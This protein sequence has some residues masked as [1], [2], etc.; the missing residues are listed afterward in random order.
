M[1]SPNPPGAG[2]LKN[3]A[4]RLAAYPVAVEDGLDFSNGKTPRL[5]LI[6][7]RGFYFIHIDDV[8]VTSRILHE[9][10]GF[11]DETHHKSMGWPTKAI[12]LIRY[13]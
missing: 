4:K 10:D 1:E 2:A 9:V 6:L 7:V 12:Y 11:N 8:M 13:S 3:P 5:I